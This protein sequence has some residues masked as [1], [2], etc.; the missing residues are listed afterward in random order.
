MIRLKKKKSEDKRH[1]EHVQKQHFSHAK[2][3]T[4]AYETDTTGLNSPTQC[5]SLIIMLY[6]NGYALFWPFCWSM[7]R[8]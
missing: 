6:L 8:L 1:F 7:I 4:T 5:D 2:L 3:S